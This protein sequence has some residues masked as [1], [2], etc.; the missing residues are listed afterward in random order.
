[1]SARGIKLYYYKAATGNFG[2]DLNSWLWDRLLPDA[3]DGVCYH[4]DVDPAGE[5][6]ETTL[7][8]GIGTLLNQ[9][10]PR[11]P[12]KVVFTS[13]AGYGHRPRIDARWMFYA[14]RGPMTSA[15]LGLPGHIAVGDG[16]MLL[17][18]FDRPP[19]KERYDVSYVPHHKSASLGPWRE[20][21]ES[22]GIHY[23]ESRDNVGTVLAEIAASDLVLT[24][25][26]HGAVVADTYRI[27]WVAISAH[28]HINA[29]KWTDWCASMGLTYD[30]RRLP[31][32]STTAHEWEALS[33]F[34][35]TLR[36]IKQRRFLRRVVTRARPSLS[37]YKRLHDVTAG[38]HEAL[39]RLKCD[40][41][42][43]EFEHAYRL[44]SS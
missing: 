14:V 15:Q 40:F 38:L 37:N 23:I 35:R 43:G 26:L 11:A 1:V 44:N 13:G 41:K 21:C 25:S 22:A 16:A 36:L 34:R 24:E 42:T 31:S 6:E 30:P 32:L 12:H 17:G 20:V 33:S 18:S 19:A 29:F 5:K 3:F 10:V 7:F 4:G 8:L 39:G 27:P 2:D 9:Q 28:P